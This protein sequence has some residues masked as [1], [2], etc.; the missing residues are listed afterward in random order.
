[1]NGEGI[2]SALAYGKLYE[3]ENVTE[4][5]KWTNT[6][7]IQTALDTV[8]KSGGGTVLIPKG[9]YCL[10]GHQEAGGVPG[11][12]ENIQ[13]ACLYICYSNIT[14][15]GSGMNET[16]IRTPGEY[17]VIKNKAGVDTVQRVYGIRIIAFKDS[18]ELITNIEFK[19]F[20]LFGGTHSTGKIH[21]PSDIATGDGWDIQHKGIAIH[22]GRVGSVK[23]EAIRVHGYRGELLYTDAE[24]QRAEFRNIN[25]FDTNAQCFNFSAHF[26]QV[27]NCHFGDEKYGCNSWIEFANYSRFPELGNGSC[28][29]KNCYFTGNRH[30][31]ISFNEGHNDGYSIFFENNFLDLHGG[32]T[33]NGVCCFMFDGGTSGPV[34][35]RNNTINSRDGA[36]SVFNSDCWE[37]RHRHKD[38]NFIVESN[39]FSGFKAMV[40]FVSAYG[41]P[42]PERM[43]NNRFEKQH[44]N[45][46]FRN[47]VFNSVTD[48]T[49][50]P[51]VILG[52]DKETMIDYLDNRWRSKCLPYFENIVFENNTFNNSVTPWLRDCY[53]SAPVFRNNLYNNC[54]LKKGGAADYS[55][56]QEITTEHNRAVPV[57]EFLYLTASK[58]VF[59]R[60]RAH[61][62][63][64]LRA[65]A[66]EHNYTVAVMGAAGTAPI[67]FK[68]DNTNSF[69]KELT[70]TENS[71]MRIRY[72]RNTEKWELLEVISGGLVPSGKGADTTKPIGADLSCHI[73]ASETVL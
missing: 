21:W 66:Y 63:M 68:P 36:I 35:I 15:S 56:I 6:E 18:K 7:T 62:P 2:Y 57:L 52:N 17:K 55:A 50:R 30:N 65:P 59:A 71:G 70:V 13:T 10:N 64:D 67:V 24:V 26:T 72:N 46:V 73:G 51:V 32:V 42:N 11:D 53:G 22:G 54:T 45:M 4:E 23:M 8:G 19:D 47:N 69:E 14:L 5:Q 43:L 60:L 28:T 12:P 20:D 3:G 9:T 61:N 58:P 16:F 34:N 44:K 27:E 37:G 38:E 48:E 39:V 40:S 29:F 31:G 1:M 25:T 41:A 33:Y 49:V